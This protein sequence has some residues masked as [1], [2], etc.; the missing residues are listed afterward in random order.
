V[1]GVLWYREGRED[2][3]DVLMNNNL[4]RTTDTGFY[5]DG[6]RRLQHQFDTRRLADRLDE[7]QVHSVFAPEDRALIESAAMFF[8]ATADAQGRPDCSYKG[9]LPGFGS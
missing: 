6:S 9:G 2:T 7:V 5:H 4:D 8:L 3:G 1:P